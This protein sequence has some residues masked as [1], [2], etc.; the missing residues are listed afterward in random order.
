M[1]I[2]K[3]IIVCYVA[4]LVCSCA[5][6]DHSYIDDR[7]QQHKRREAELLAA[8]LT[9]S[10]NIA[11]DSLTNIIYNDLRKIRSGYMFRDWP[12]DEISVHPLYGESCISLTFDTVTA[13]VL[14]SGRYTDWGQLNDRYA[15]REIVEYPSENAAELLFRGRL[16]TIALGELYR[17]LPG[18]IDVHGCSAGEPLSPALDGGTRYNIYI[19]QG[20]KGIEYLFYYSEHV[21]G[22][23]VQSCWHFVLRGGEP[24]VREGI[25]IPGLGGWANMPESMKRYLSNPSHN[26]YILY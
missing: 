3:R 10:V 15:V 1:I 18:V 17:E 25:P 2:D 9:G 22:E 14:F 11:P 8:Y 26:R 24:L 13:A 6:M 12:L 5:Y 4:A 20:E 19:R 23:S 16:N 21:E 7:P